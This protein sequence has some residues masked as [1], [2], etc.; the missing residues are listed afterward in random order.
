VTF[1]ASTSAPVD[2]DPRLPDREG[3]SVA[4]LSEQ[5]VWRAR[6]RHE[7]SEI[8]AYA[9]APSPKVTVIVVSYRPQEYLIECLQQLRGQTAR[10]KIDYE[11]LLADSGGLEHLRDR[12]GSLCDVELRL[13]DGISLNAARNTAMA[14]ARGEL[15]AIVDDDGL[16]APTFV[17]VICKTFEDR[18]I[19]AIRGRI[20]AKDHPYFCTLAP[21]YDRGDRIID[22][23]LS[24]EGHMAIR[25]SLYLATGG[26]PD[27]FYGHEGMLLAYRIRERFPDQRVVYVPE[28]VMRHDYV[29]TWTK[30]LR[31]STKIHNAK[32]QLRQAVPPAEFERFMRSIRA[33]YPS[34]PL[35]WDRRLAKGALDVMRWALVHAP[36]WAL[37]RSN[38]G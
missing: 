3:A 27:D 38:G 18:A 36:S 33:G 15:V 23:V 16:V 2:L 37:R 19:G 29:E 35:P 1:D 12:T 31:K 28:L 24:T 8:R 11:V 20:V 10:G 5:A 13:R 17:E 32:D 7:I 9:P 14:W 25:R 4:E 26:F 22:D 21:H 6:Y 34:V 30:F